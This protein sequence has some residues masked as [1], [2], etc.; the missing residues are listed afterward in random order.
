MTSHEL[1]TPAD[2]YMSVLS[3]LHGIEATVPSAD[4]AR[5]CR[6]APCDVDTAGS[7]SSIFRAI[8]TPKAMPRPLD[9][10]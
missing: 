2:E 8:P 4:T 9:G 10:P 7:I 5:A 1:D 6:R 3:L